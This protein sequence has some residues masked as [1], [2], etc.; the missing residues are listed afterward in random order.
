MKKLL[1]IF[2]ILSVMAQ[3][4]AVS[5]EEPDNR[6]I[7]LLTA[8]GIT[9]NPSENEVSRG[10]FAAMV[11][12]MLG[13]TDRSN[14]KQMFSDIPE[15]NPN[16]G[17]INLAYS[18]GL[19]NGTGNGLFEPEA[20]I[21]L[22][23][24]AKVLVCALGYEIQADSVGS[25]P[26]SFLTTA[27]KIGIL[28]NVKIG[29]GAFVDYEA[30]AAMLY[31]SLTINLMVQDSFGGSEGFK[32][33]Q[34]SSLLKD[35][36]HIERLTGTVN[37]V[38]QSSLVGESSLPR[39]RI[40]INRKI[41]NSGDIDT[42]P[43]LGFSVEFYVRWDDEDAS[44]QPEILYIEKSDLN[45]TILTI[46]ARDISVSTNKNVFAY[47]T[48]SSEKIFEKKLSPGLDVIYNGKALDPV[49]DSHLKPDSGEVTLL[50]NDSDGIIDIA[51]VTSYETYV[52]SS[53]DAREYIVYDRY[54]NSP[55][56]LDT[57]DTTDDIIIRKN[58]K[59]V[60]FSE[61]KV[62]DV[63]SIIR[64]VPT[65]GINVIRV[66]IIN[67]S[68]T[69]AIEATFEEKGEKKVTV[70]GEDYFI[71]KSYEKALGIKNPYAK[72]L[73]AGYFGTFLLDIHDEIAAVR[74][75]E[76]MD[77]AYGYLIG[78]NIKQE[79]G[80]NVR[81]KA[82]VANGQM[83]S[84][85]IFEG[86]DKI[87]FNGNPTRYT[88][89]EIM[90]AAEFKNADGSFKEQLVKFKFDNKNMVKELETADTQPSDERFTLDA[91]FSPAD[92]EAV[93]R[94]NPRSINGQYIIG[95]NT[96]M[97]GI[98][99]YADYE[100]GDVQYNFTN[101][102]SDR[103]YKFKV[104]DVNEANI[105]AAVIVPIEKKQSE[106]AYNNAHL[107]II[108]KVSMVMNDDSV[109]TQRVTGLYK[110]MEIS[111]YLKPGEGSLR[112]GDIVQI[113]ANTS[114]EIIY[115]RRIYTSGTTIE[116]E[117]S[118]IYSDQT[119]ADVYVEGNNTNNNGPNSALHILYGTLYAVSGNIFSVTM[120]GGATRYASIAGNTAIIYTYENGASGITA[121]N[122][123]IKDMMPSSL[124]SLNGSRVLVAKRGDEV[125]DIV[126]FK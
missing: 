107:V 12:K 113:V 27:S 116:A 46:Q 93:W 24:A 117:E 23:M 110:G 51:I 64:S 21:T 15:S 42:L 48:K 89:E 5:A 28:R 3:G 119:F 25:Y 55:I 126:I 17:S 80:S 105:P 86:L 45:N 122:G 65:D 88:G 104:Y 106:I 81:F 70:E 83:G 44:S 39:G 22:E 92:R 66:E 40:E 118:F 2:L 41:Y 74:Y 20:P 97:I 10:E 4:I 14:T 115:Y 6:T 77:M 75:G 59:L 54:G 100:D 32:I 96:V 108:S 31:N 76:E 112:R 123:T 19:M 16:A 57:T 53:V 47:K 95:S 99:Q 62:W 11:V 29:L 56:S 72:T 91:D 78:I 60:D 73:D 49:S 38:Y 1:I 63:L 98:P 109:L 26:Q 34:G 52:V 7:N 103:K 43:Y 30:A 50:D 111:Y 94:S 84:A 35:R 102:A 36:L 13:H 58:G 101:L 33:I 125:W 67:K 121:A 120:D 124:P 18:L 87:T 9:E 114:N 71:S 79:L 90:D 69:S 8:L 82:Y 37:A 61:I 68:I 85:Q